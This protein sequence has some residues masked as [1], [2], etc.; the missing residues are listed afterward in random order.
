MEKWLLK[1]A[2]D[3]GIDPSSFNLPNNLKGLISISKVQNI[4]KNIGLHRFVKALINGHSPSMILLKHW[5]TLF[6]GNQ[7]EELNRNEL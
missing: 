4:N 1:N 6:I 7:L 2:L 5:I 3:I